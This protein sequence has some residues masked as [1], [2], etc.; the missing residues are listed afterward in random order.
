MLLQ[1]LVSTSPVSESDWT[2]GHQSSLPCLTYF[3]DFLTKDPP[4]DGT[5]WAQ[6]SYTVSERRRLNVNSEYA[7]CTQIS[8]IGRIFYSIYTDSA[9]P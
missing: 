4:D 5:N 9:A 3:D 7:V 1:I 8:S 2:S 6:L